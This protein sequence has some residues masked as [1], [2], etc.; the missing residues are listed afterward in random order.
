[1][2]T[3]SWI[4]Q[5]RHKLWLFTFCLFISTPVNAGVNI[6]SVDFNKITSRF[7]YSKSG[8]ESFV[9]AQGAIS[10]QVVGL[11]LI[12]PLP[13]TDQRQSYFGAGHRYTIF[14]IDGVATQ[15]N[16]H[17]HTFYLP[18]FHAQQTERGIMR[19]AVAPALSAS[20]NIIK[21]RNNWR[22]ETL[23]LLG[24]FRFE[25]SNGWYVGGCADY[26]FG[27]FEIY[28]VFG[29]RFATMDRWQLEIGFPDS[30]ARYRLHDEF[31]LQITIGPDGNQWEVADEA[32]SQR[33]RFGYQSFLL[34]FS[35]DWKPLKRLSVS[36]GVARHFEQELNLLLINGQRVTLDAED[37][38]EL[39]ASLHWVFGRIRD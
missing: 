18:Y 24:G 35:L 28:P 9:N 32:F 20:S 21:T 22:S 15:T 13:S 26:R 30:A 23:Q 12:G 17:V 6:C 29:L 3:G 5:P 33:S 4:Y 7:V 2:N 8:K 11:D 1:M 31:N 19:F 36:F 25:N 14:D 39:S 38:N 27:E 34:A 16:G 10:Q 37:T